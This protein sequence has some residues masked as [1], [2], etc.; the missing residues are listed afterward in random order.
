MI[1]DLT[2]PLIAIV[3]L[4][5]ALFL[6]FF[7]LP[8]DNEGLSQG[9]MLII[10]GIM[11]LLLIRHPYWGNILV[12]SS[13]PLISIIPQL[14]FSG[15]SVSLLGVATLGAFFVRQLSNRGAKI[16]WNNALTYGGL[17]FIWLVVTNPVAAFSSGEDRVWAFT[18]FQLFLFA[19]L[20]AQLFDDPAKH[21]SLIW[22]FSGVTLISAVF[23][24]SQGGIA[25]SALLSERAEGLAGGSNSAARY[26]VVGLVLIYYLRSTTVNG[27]LRFILFVSMGIVILGILYTVSRTGLLLLVAAA[28]LILTLQVES[29]RRT[30]ALMVLL[31]I[32]LIVWLFADNI[33]FIFATILPSIRSGTDT[34][35]LRYKLWEAG[36][37]MW[38]DH[39]I[40]GVGIGQY[41]EQ[42]VYYG[43]D[44]LPFNKLRLGAH[45]MYVQ[46]LA[47][48]GLIG[49]FLFLA[50]FVTS[51][52]SLWRIGRSKNIEIARLAQVWF[53]ILIIMLLGGLTKH[54]HYDK[55]LWIVVGLGTS[56][57]AKNL[58]V[59]A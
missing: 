50:I 25:E 29:K 31:L 10:L 46:V 21:R 17:F 2:R 51:A 44:L 28:G 55:L 34:V 3:A 11:V 35:G 27:F 48:T 23:A 38:L 33:I 16:V 43:A 40:Q 37:R 59:D 7:L 20:S 49:L 36:W 22:F 32:L 41:M 56:L 47:E 6:I 8:V 15:S 42:L 30:P 4:I 9:L 18:F 24:L 14:P 39:P 13:L 1:R 26:F 57:S 58:K 53:I 12:I 19:W 54:D 45:N 5:S 52:L